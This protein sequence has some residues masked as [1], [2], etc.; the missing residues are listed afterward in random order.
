MDIWVDSFRKGPWR[1]MEVGREVAD[2]RVVEVDKESQVG[3]DKA[4]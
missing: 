3:E 2:I 1:R 4:G